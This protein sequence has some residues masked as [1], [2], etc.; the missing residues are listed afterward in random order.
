MGKNK[1]AR[2]NI[3]Q[4]V[5]FMS[6]LDKVSIRPGVSILSILKHIE[7]DPWYA[8]AEFVDNAIDSYL[9]Y[10]KELK[11]IEGNNFALE[12]RIELNDVDKKIV[13]KDNAAGILEK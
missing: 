4:Y 1:I 2:R 8:L 12:V 5:I 11:T 10:E 9:K 3:S 7:Y 13:I 6:Q